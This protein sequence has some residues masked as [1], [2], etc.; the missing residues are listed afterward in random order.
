[1]SFFSL[2]IRYLS[3]PFSCNHALILPFGL[4]DMEK[5]VKEDSRTLRTQ[6]AKELQ[7]NLIEGNSATIHL[8]IKRKKKGKKSKKRR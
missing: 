5:K 3:R 7:Q 6:A 4:I 8:T 2:L 1:M